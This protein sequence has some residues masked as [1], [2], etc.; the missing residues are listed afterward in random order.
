MK[1]L[2]CSLMALGTFL[3]V[4]SQAKAEP[5][6]D[7]TTLDVPHSSSTNALGINSSGRI[8]G[9]YRDASGTAHGFLLHKGTYMTL[10]VPGATS[11]RPE[12]INASGRIA[13]W[14]IDASPCLTSAGRVV[15]VSP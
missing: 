11:T 15:D 14:Y 4:A 9:Y 10:D 13:G 3:G 12:K 1:R 5:S 2:F 8:V 6:Y 7:F